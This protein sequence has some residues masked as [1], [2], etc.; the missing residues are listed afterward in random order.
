VFWF[1]LLMFIATTVIGALLKPK[2]RLVHSSLGDFQ[3][4]TAQESRP[5]PYIGGTVMIKGGNTVWW[6]DLH[7][8]SVKAGGIFGIGG[9]V[10]G[11]KYKLGIQ[12]M[13]CHGPIDALISLYCDNKN[14]RFTQTGMDP[15][16]VNINMPGLFGGDHQGG[17]LSGNIALY[18]GTPTQGSDPYLSQKQTAAV[19]N[20]TYSGVGNGGLAFLAPGPNAVNETITITAE[21][22]F[23]DYGRRFFSVDGTV[24]GHIGRAVETIY[25]QA[26]QIVF[27]ITVGSSRYVTGDQYSVTTSTAR[28]SPS[29]PKI[30]Y[31]V[32]Q[33]FYVGT[34]SYP[35]PI[36]FV[37]RRCPDPLGMGASFA[38]LNGDAN[39]VFLIIELM[40]N[41]DY[42]LGFSLA[43]F[44][45]PKWQA[46][47]TTIKNED[48]GLSFM[49]DSE[50]T[51]D[52]LIGEILRHIDGVVY[53]DPQT[54]LWTITL[55][56]GGY[57]PTTLPVL[58]VD[59]ADQVDFSRASWMET[60]NKVLVEFTDRQAIFG[61][62]TMPAY[63]HANVAIS[64]SER[65]ETFQFNG[66]SRAS[67][68]SLVAMR[69]LKTV[70]FPLGKLTLKVN[71]TAWGFRMGGIFRFTWLPYGISNEVFRIIRIAYGE[72][73][74][75]QIT[76][77]AVEDIFGIGYT[78][79]QAPPDSGWVNPTGTPGTAAFER[80]EEVPYWFAQ[81]GIRVWTFMGRQDT[82]ELSYDVYQ[83][84]GAGDTFTVTNLNFCPVGHLTLPYLAATPARDATGFTIDQGGSDLDQLAGTDTSGLFLGLNM[85]LIDEEIV[86]WRTLTIG[87]T[88]YQIG[89]VLRGQLNTVPADHLAGA[90]V[91]F[92]TAGTAMT[93]ANAY[94]ND[95]NVKA[96]F[97]PTNRSGQLP[98][99]Q[100]SQLTLQTRS[101]YLRPYPPGNLRIGANPYGV[102][103][104]TIS[105]DLTFAW[106]SRNRLTQTTGQT[107]ILQDAGDI[108]PE[109]GTTY[110]V[111]IWLNNALVRRI[112]GITAESYTYTQAQYTIDDPTGT[113]PVTIKLFSHTGAAAP[114]GLDSFQPQLFTTQ[115]HLTPPGTYTFVQ[116]K[117]AF[118]NSDT[119]RVEFTNAV[120]TQQINGG[121]VTNP[122]NI[123]DGNDATYCEFYCPSNHS[124][125]P[126]LAVQASATVDG[127]PP[128]GGGTITSITFS[129]KYEVVQNDIDGGQAAPA[130]SIALGL[131]FL[132][133]QGAAGAGPVGVTTANL[134]LP[135]DFL[136]QGNQPID[137]ATEQVIIKVNTDQ[138]ATVG[139][140]KLRIYA[141]YFTVARSS[142][143]NA[144]YSPILHLTPGNFVA[145]GLVMGNSN[146]QTATSITDQTNTPFIRVPGAHV[147]N[148]NVYN[149]GA[150]E[151]WYRQN[152]QSSLPTRLKATW[153][154]GGGYSQIRIGEYHG[155]AL[156]SAVDNAGTASG[157]GANSVGPVA[158]SH[159][160]D[161]ILAVWMSMSSGCTAPAGFTDRTSGGASFE[162]MQTTAAGNVTVTQGG[163]SPNN[164]IGVVV[165]F[166]ATG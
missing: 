109:S 66:V 46:A 60:F 75:G 31:A 43:K 70:D 145:V 88:T 56:R 6:G 68:A 48:L 13:L 67:V 62:R 4:P 53:R 41:T 127:A 16:I 121:T 25:F 91:W 45:I 1:L 26:G 101:R 94:G 61:K 36:N 156:T 159:N 165:G 8:S 131:E 86:A 147:F 153:P 119:T 108:T 139:A 72:I 17:G 115:M 11:F 92:F 79:F 149:G 148:I 110:S 58:T 120:A 10:V 76:I 140:V 164:F 157:N 126:G 155:I 144:I 90:L 158:M 106:S 129:V 133:A 82:T 37:I 33:Q 57:D 49:F 15:A 128:D 77:D 64:G 116:Y 32:F 35:K 122:N 7:V 22:S 123:I 9:Q 14:V 162:D 69:V 143:A 132:V 19:A 99:A 81:D 65:P 12:Y 21:N 111:E 138:A 152:W 59:N 23:D 3:F 27:L 29:Y 73:A 85:A 47:A 5:I 96:K 38:N 71:R 102:R 89:D 93:Q 80:L 28:V 125:S 166:I 84:F 97:L 2:S 134:N 78:A 83:D 98:I 95:L 160:S 104:P 30:C 63:D 55:A 146:E 107:M 135:L 112:D 154:Q 103:P 52:E 124:I 24:S 136:L 87:G 163:C 54:A 105:G 151:V 161:L 20:P 142:T 39:G 114:A 118:S 51:A 74:S 50:A 137:I 42:G 117:E 113:H 130:W 18:Y 150:L 34:S 141:A 100:A 40:T 44:D